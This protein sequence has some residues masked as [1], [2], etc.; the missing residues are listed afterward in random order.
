MKTIIHYFMW[1]ILPFL[2]SC[3]GSK[4]MRA[5]RSR[6][7]IIKEAQARET[8]QVKHLSETRAARWKQN[9]L[10]SV[11]NK[12]YD[13]RV[14]RI[15]AQ[16]DSLSQEIAGLE[17]L[18][19]DKKKFRKAYRKVVWPR[20]EALDSFRNENANRRQ[21]YLMLEDGL[22]TT[23][24]ALFD[25]AAFFGPGKYVIPGDKAEMV[26]RSFAPLLDSVIRFSDKYKNLPQTAIL[27][28]IGFADGTGFDPQGHLY[29]ELTGMTGKPKATRPELN[30]KLSELRAETLASRL[31]VLLGSRLEGKAETDNIKVEFIGLGKGE[32]YPFPNISDYRE[33]DERRRIVLCYWAVLPN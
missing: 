14:Q 13:F 17:S 24:Y 19:G 5:V 29:A 1:L 32:Q 8:S 12:R 3:A 22:N 25:L 4:K 30:K 33:D 10:D 27:V 23:Q 2:V 6:L 21:V 28:V 26:A 18:V 15:D 7:D 31:K 16:M 9:K 11:I 20:L